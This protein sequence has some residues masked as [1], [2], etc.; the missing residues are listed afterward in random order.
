MSD[1]FILLSFLTALCGY[2]VFSNYVENRKIREKNKVLE[3][4]DSQSLDRKLL[5]VAKL[6]SEISQYKTNHILHFLIAFF[7]FGLWIIPWFFIAQS[8]K[9][10]RIEITQ[11]KNEMISRVQ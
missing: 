10:K 7:S 8:N 3:R 4:V 11:F 5:E 9:N 1:L 2:F 6:Q